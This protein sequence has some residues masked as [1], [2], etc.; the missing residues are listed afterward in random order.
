MTF[1]VN[2]DAG[3]SSELRTAQAFGGLNPIPCLSRAD[4]PCSHH[5]QSR[6]CQ[7]QGVAEI[8]LVIPILSLDFY[9]PLVPPPCHPRQSSPVIII[10]SHVNLRL[11]HP[12]FAAAYG[13]YLNLINLSVNLICLWHPH[14]AAAY[15][16]SLYLINPLCQLNLRLWHP[17]LAA[18]LGEPPELCPR[19]GMGPSGPFC[20]QPEQ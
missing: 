19:R 14:F 12:H 9:L 6:Q 16:I 3:W 10:L 18:A 11:W 17:H 15:G 1:L 20:M 13:N 8:P 2:G 7:I 5:T 4:S